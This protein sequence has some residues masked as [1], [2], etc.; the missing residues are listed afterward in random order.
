MKI[1]FHAIL[2]SIAL[3]SCSS[4]NAADLDNYSN[5]YELSNK[6]F[7]KIGEILN[8]NLELK[9]DS[10]CGMCNLTEGAYS[11][12]E[13]L[14]LAAF[15][16]CKDVPGSED[17]KGHSDVFNLCL[18]TLNRQVN[19]S[20]ITTS[21]QKNNEIKLLLKQLHPIIINI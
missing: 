6:I 1:N 15:Y 20:E 8:T 7:N 11:T 14:K 5:N 4:I 19:K 3:I 9:M 21:E 12:A 16:L 13:Q 2:V 17:F 10:C 18:D